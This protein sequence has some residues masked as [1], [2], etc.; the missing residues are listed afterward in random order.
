MTTPAIRLLRKSYPKAQIH[1]LTQ[2][3]SD[4]IFEHNPY[5]NKI[6]NLPRKPSK[7]DWVK[8]FFS[9]KKEQ[10]DTVLDFYGKPK[11]AFFSWLLRIENRIGFDLK[12]RN[13]FYN[14]TVKISKNIDYSPLH[15]IDLLTSLHIDTKNASANLDFFIEETDR[16]KI[17]HILS[18]L[19]IKRDRPLITISPVSR[20]DYKVWPASK[21][22]KLCDSIIRR[23]KAQILFVWGPGEEHFIEKV[24]S[25]MKEKYLEMN[26]ILSLKETV[27]LFEL[28]D[29][30]IGNDNG[31]MHF[32]IAASTPTIAIFGKPNPINWTPPNQNKHL[33]I[34]HDPGCKNSCVYPKCNLE[35]IRDITT[36]KTLDL[37]HI[38]MKRLGF[39]IK[40]QIKTKQSK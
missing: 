10:Y 17:R 34:N 14:K 28:T 25:K 7:M 18:D 13:F 23:Y 30:H 3:P 4:Q 15:K 16:K 2:K 27:A 20:R 37:V 19:N 40:N 38:Q 32:A 8:V 21:F 31:P 29:I 33:F 11:T 22:S 26:T 24:T 12:G 39:S 1:I 36:Q 6:V 5:V 35:C 9:L